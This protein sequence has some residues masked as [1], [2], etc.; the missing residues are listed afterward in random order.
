M[1]E[2]GRR[3]RSDVVVGERSSGAVCGEAL[4]GSGGCAARL[5]HRLRRLHRRHLRRRRRHV[6]VQG[7]LLAGSH[8]LRPIPLQHEEYGKRSQTSHDGYHV[9]PFP[10][11]YFHLL[12]TIYNYRSIHL[13]YVIN[14][15]SIF[16]KNY[17]RNFHSH[18]IVI[19]L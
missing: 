1:I 9:I 12:F 11:S 7:E 2:E 17:I 15:Y 16:Y 10:S 6:P 13:Y 3:K 4:R 8:F 18:R 14:N 5:A 19:C